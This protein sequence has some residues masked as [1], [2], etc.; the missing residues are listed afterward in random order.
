M[1]K[2]LDLPQQLLTCFSCCPFLHL[3]LRT[4]IATFADVAVATLDCTVVPAP[5][6]ILDAALEVRM[7]HLTRA[8]FIVLVW[9]FFVFCLVTGCLCCAVLCCAVVDE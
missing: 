7:F 3:Q 4:F 5:Q 1:G 8:D 9:P 6:I 2:D